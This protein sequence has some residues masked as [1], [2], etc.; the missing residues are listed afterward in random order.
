MPPIDSPILFLVAG[1]WIAPALWAN[2]ELPIDTE[3]SRLSVVDGAIFVGLGFATRCTRFGEAEDWSMRIERDA[4][5]ITYG[6]ETYGEPRDFCTFGPLSFSAWPSLATALASPDFL[7]EDSDTSEVRFVRVEFHRE[8]CTDM[9]P[10]QCQP[11]ST[12]LAEAALSGIPR[13]GRSGTLQS[14][15]WKGTVGIP[16]SPATS[17]AIREDRD[18]VAMS[19]LGGDADAGS[20]WL[21]ASGPLEQGVAIMPTFTAELGGCVRC[22]P[23][24]IATQVSGSTKLWVI[25]ANEVWV[26]SAGREGLSME[27]WRPWSMRLTRS[28]SWVEPELAELGAFFDSMAVLTGTWIDVSRSLSADGLVRI[29]EA[30]AGCVNSADPCLG[31]WIYS[32]DWSGGSGSVVCGDQGRCRFTDSGHP[33]VVI[34]VP[35]ESIGS[36]RLFSSDVPCVALEA[37]DDEL[38]SLFLI[39]MGD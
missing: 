28:M 21:F 3:I 36:D 8:V 1:L 29:G 11:E 15:F 30:E 2:E 18:L 13:P 20:A 32:A 10:A 23:Q 17:I 19:W 33:D 34:D 39:R 31:G 6:I 24:M 16:G 38:G 22:N 26:S 5:V 14:G 35:L 4:L 9:V 25:N 7:P 27:P 37:C 12:V